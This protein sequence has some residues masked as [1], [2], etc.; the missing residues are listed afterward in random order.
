MLVWLSFGVIALTFI[1]GLHKLFHAL[2][3]H[4][5]SGKC[6]F[7]RKFITALFIG[8]AIEGFLIFFHEATWIVDREDSSIDFAMQV[9]K[10]E[11]IQPFKDKGIPPFILLDID[12][13]THN[14]WDEPLF[15][16]RDRLKELIDV[17]VNDGAKVV[18]VDVDVS[19]ATPFK[20]LPLPEGN[21]YH[22]YDE[23]L[24]KYL[25]KYGEDCKEGKRTPCPPI[26]LARVF[27]PLKEKDSSAENPFHLLSTYFGHKPLSM[28]L[29]EPRPSFLDEVVKTSDPYVQW[30]SVAFSSSTDNVLR[31][32]W[33][34]QPI[35]E[36]QELKEVIPSVELLVAALV[37]NNTVKEAKQQFKQLEE[38][39]KNKCSNNGE[40]EK[41]G[42]KV[43]SF[44]KDLNVHEDT[45]GIRPR[46]MY[47][48]DWKPLVYEKEANK[49]MRWPSED[50]SGEYILTVI[51]AQDLKK[52][53]GT[54][55]DH[56]V[57][58]GGSY[59]DRGDIHLTPLGR[60]PGG[61]V[62]IN[63][64]HTL[65][66]YQEIKP[67]NEWFHQWFGSFLGVENIQILV[68]M[69]LIVLVSLIFTVFSSSF[70]SIMVVGGVIILPL[71]YFSVMA[72]GQWGVWIDFV[73][74][75]LAVQFHYIAA[76]FEQMAEEK[77]QQD[78]LS[79]EIKLLKE[80]LNKN[81]QQIVS[82]LKT[83]ISERNL[84]TV[85]EVK[86]LEEQIH[87]VIAEVK[88]INPH[89]Q[90]VV[91][92]EIIKAING[93]TQQII[94]SL[95]EVNKQQN[96]VQEGGVEQQSTNISG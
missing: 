46:I 13:E 91:A 63:A 75:L 47:K 89:N 56:I 34:W 17:P 70:W 48:L 76:N 26:V 79:P 65:L 33:L 15:T 59:S 61:L 78:R 53:I 77:K 2:I 10:E 16:P 88:T 7:F 8:M 12:D 14:A 60:M 94:S 39:E 54:F 52:H 95:K 66:E 41:I 1:Y 62:I 50:K 57:V 31:R 43:L 84:R 36:K 64:I 11:G 37:R 74:P 49:L 20:P 18:V 5:H 44:G 25:K 83:V 72:L 92:A 96:A 68:T 81:G 40:S 19:Q 27:R 82:D 35:C 58:I 85:E 9:L 22:P 73:L 30:A 86:E 42:D 80:E 87:L 93:Q 51:S 38:R 69:V 21:K 32:W 90:Q 67:L 6:Y 3:P 45:S 29:Y 55:K 71:T 4:C 23:D 24:F 28:P